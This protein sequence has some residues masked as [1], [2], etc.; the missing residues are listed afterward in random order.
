M[1]L[2]KGKKYIADILEDLVG[3]IILIA[4]CTSSWGEVELPDCL[5]DFADDRQ[6]SK[7][8]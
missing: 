8:C 6:E 4:G 7:E 1:K 2:E 3:D 5:R